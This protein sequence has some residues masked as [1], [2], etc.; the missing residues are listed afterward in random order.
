MH[1]IVF[2]GTS[3]YCQPLIESLRKNFNLLQIITKSSDFQLSYLT[4]LS[5]DLF[6][7]ADYGKIIAEEIF[8]LPKYGTINVHFSRLPKYRGPSPVQYSILNGE[9]N[10]WVTLIEMGEKVDTGKIIKQ[11]EYKINPQNHTT[12][13]LY[14]ELFKK[15]AADLPEI[16]KDYISGKLKAENQNEKEATYTKLIKKE[17]G[18]L[19]L[20]DLIKALLGN[21]YS[22]VI[23]RK[24]R[25]FDPWPGV[26]T[27][28]PN[29]KRLKILK[30][31]LIPNSLQTINYKLQTDLVQLEGKKPVSWKQFLEGYPEIKNQLNL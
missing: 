11:L 26:W 9:K 2:F 30:T 7:V 15:I 4:S 18:F 24:V 20:N 27:R 5:A 16:I 23:E 29:G 6:V 28:L 22:L 14:S 19:E 13:S 31:H 12:G 25:A 10:S 17:D 21:E 1:K 3:N 8:T